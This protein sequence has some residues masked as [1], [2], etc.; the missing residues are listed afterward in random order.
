MLFFIG[1]DVIKAKNTPQA[2]LNF[3]QFASMYTKYLN[4]SNNG[5]QTPVMVVITKADLLTQQELAQAYETVKDKWRFL[6]G[7]G[8]NLTTGITAVSLGKNLTNEGG[9]LEG[10][11]DIRA[12][13]GNLSIPILFSLYHVMGQKIEASVGKISETE[14]SLNR[15]NGQ[16]N[17]ELSR[18]SFARFF[19]NKETSIRNQIDAHKANLGRET[20]ILQKLNSSMAAIKEFLLSGAQIYIN[21]ERV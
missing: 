2:I 1:A 15:A 6:F 9:V 21:G 16:L 14:S 3:G 4:E 18:S 7:R 5:A 10:E 17:H 19:I 12:T 11:L 20:E 13:A 8:T